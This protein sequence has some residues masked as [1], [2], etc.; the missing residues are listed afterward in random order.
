VVGWPSTL[1]CTSSSPHCNVAWRDSSAAW[2]DGA[3]PGGQPRGAPTR[4]DD[5]SAR[6]SHC[7]W[8]RGIDPLHGGEH[9]VR[10][11]AL[12]RPVEGETPG[13]QTWTR[14]APTSGP[15]SRDFLGAG[16]EV[17][18]VSCVTATPSRRL[19]RTGSS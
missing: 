2:R 7:V 12:A 9:G 13:S 15:G 3:R 17:F 6:G 11:V 14:A 4:I 19:A 1:A 10:A 5:R 16:P 18:R 8:A